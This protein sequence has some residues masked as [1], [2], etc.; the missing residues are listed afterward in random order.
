ME[1]MVLANKYFMEKYPDVSKTKIK[2]LDKKCL[3]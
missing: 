3:L 2:Q 1:S